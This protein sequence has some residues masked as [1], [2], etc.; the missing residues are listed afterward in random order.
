MIGMLRPRHVLL[1][2]SALVGVFAWVLAGVQPDFLT[3]KLDLL[4]V[5]ALVSLMVALV[6]L[7]VTVQQ[8][9]TANT[10]P[11]DVASMLA[12]RVR[13]A[14]QDVLQKLLGGEAHRTDID[15]VRVPTPSPYAQEWVESGSTAR[16]AEHYR[17]LP[18]GRLVITGA[19]GS[20]KT[21]V[22][23]GLVLRL[24][25]PQEV[26]TRILLRIP[27]ARLDT[28]EMDSVVPTE[29]AVSTWMVTWPRLRGRSCERRCRAA[30]RTGLGR[31]SRTSCRERNI[32]RPS[33]RP[34][35]E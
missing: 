24:L 32:P 1:A 9:T 12:G 27:A 5:V 22:A 33:C 25:D 18:G 3:G 6:T 35:G 23:I 29:R 17:E 10:K 2:A 26:S 7:L 19:A 30:S 16:I 21:V 28:A 31:S 15:F 14:E 4:N 34:W 8:G 13:S 11:A 20:G